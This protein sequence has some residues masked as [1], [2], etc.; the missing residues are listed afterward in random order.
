[1][2]AFEQRFGMPSPRKT[3][4]CPHKRN[5]PLHSEMWKIPVGAVD[6]IP[7]CDVFRYCPFFNLDTIIVLC[8]SNQYRL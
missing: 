5:A 4:V 2:T 7:N 8:L 6:S 3:A 1:M